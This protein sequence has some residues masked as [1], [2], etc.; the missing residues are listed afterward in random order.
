[1]IFTV[2]DSPFQRLQLQI[3]GSVA[4]FEQAMIR[5]RQREGIAQAKKEGKYKSRKAALDAA[6][7]AEVREQIN[8]GAKIAQIARDLGVSRQTLYSSL[9]RIG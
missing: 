5:E 6:Q 3:I 4:E 8:A 7:I 9:A 2:E 1:M